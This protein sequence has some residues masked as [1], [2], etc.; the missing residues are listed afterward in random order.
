MGILGEGMALYPSS[1]RYA[2]RLSLPTMNSL[3]SRSLSVMSL[4]TE[5]P[6]RSASE[7]RGLS[8]RTMSQI[9]LLRRT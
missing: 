3:R 5:D 9:W 4:H 1:S 8:P 6:D 2:P 7:P